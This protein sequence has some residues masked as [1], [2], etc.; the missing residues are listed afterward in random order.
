MDAAIAAVAVQGVV[1]PHMTGIGGDCF[2]LFSMK[3]SAPVALDGSGRAPSGAAAAWYADRGFNGI[4][5]ESPHAVTIPGAISAWC[6]LIED[7]GTKPLAELLEPA[8]KLA[9]HGLL[10][11]PRVEYDWKRNATKLV[12][13]ENARRV[14]LPSGKAPEVGDRFYNPVLADTL[15]KIA[16]SGSAAF[17]EGEVARTLTVKRR[18]GGDT[19]AAL[20]RGPPRPGPHGAG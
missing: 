8:I 16:R 17:Y 2:A 6:R 1:E 9:E 4:P 13:D 7:N 12:A 20:H 3:G 18:A 10:V 14:F 19:A 5:A 11:T 15:R